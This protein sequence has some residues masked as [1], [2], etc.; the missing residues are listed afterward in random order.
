M[1]GS[2]IDLYPGLRSSMLTAV[3]GEVP[4]IL[5]KILQGISSRGDFP[6]TRFRGQKISPHESRSRAGIKGPGRGVGMFVKDGLE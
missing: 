5:A 6:A 4:K 2:G 1:T 3:H